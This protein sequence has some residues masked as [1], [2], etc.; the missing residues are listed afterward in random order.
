MVE[1]VLLLA[2]ADPDELTGRIAFSLQLLLERDR[3]VYDLA[4][5]ELVP[6]WQPPDLP[7]V[8]ARQA[9]ALEALGWP[10]PFEF[11]RRS[12]PSP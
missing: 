11:R 7:A 2:T 9:A 6:G 12:S 3:P 10:E 5:A 1:A 4:G 8:I